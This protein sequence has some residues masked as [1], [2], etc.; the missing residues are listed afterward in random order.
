MAGKK[1][2]YYALVM[3]NEGPK[4]VTNILPHHP[5]VCGILYRL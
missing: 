2:H 1:Y 3:T 5:A 4:Y